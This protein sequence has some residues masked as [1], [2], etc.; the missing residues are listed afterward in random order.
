MRASLYRTQQTNV[1]ETDLNNAALMILAGDARVDGFELEVAGHL[2]DYWQ[3]YGGYSYMYGI[4]DKSPG[5][6]YQQRSRQSSRER[7]GAYLQF[8]DYVSFRRHALRDRRRRQRGFEPLR[9]RESAARLP[10]RRHVHGDA[11]G[12]VAFLTKVPA[13]ATFDAMA[14]YYVNEKLDLQLNVSNIFNTFYYDQSIAHGPRRGSDGAADGR[15]QVLRGPEGGGAMLLQIPKVLDASQV[16]HC[17]QALE[18]AEWVDGRATAGHQ[19]ERVKN[20]MQVPEGHPVARELGDMILAALERNPLF[21]TAT[22][23][24]KVYPPLFNR[25][26]G[27]ETYGTHIDGAIREVMR[28]RYRV[29]TDLSATLFL[30]PPEEYD[31]GELTIEGTTARARVKLPAGDMV[32]YPATSLH[33]VTPTPVAR[34][35]RRSSGCKAWS[36]ATSSG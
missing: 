10:E 5:A 27:G 29:R 18:R 25:Y 24:L 15:L 9:Q 20:N 23:P 22:L 31:G 2:T 7:P 12:V 19:S 28:S 32:I 17:R 21:I 16:A 11:P 14:K 8:L 30:T 4:I 3:V 26:Q 33:H 6:G 36:A 34:A 35:S 13:Y 1:R